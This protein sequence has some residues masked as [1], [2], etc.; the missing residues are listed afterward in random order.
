ML[1]ADDFITI[2]TVEIN[3]SE[4]KTIINSLADEPLFSEIIEDLE[5]YIES[6]TE[7]GKEVAETV[8]EK[9]KEIVQE[10]IQS[11]GAIDS[12][13]MFDQVE[14]LEES[15]LSYSVAETAESPEGHFYPA[16]IE[17]GR[18]EIVPINAK[19]LMFYPKG[20]FGEPIFT[21]KASATKPKP[22]WEPSLIAIESNIDA[23][24]ELIINGVSI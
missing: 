6:Y 18:D 24:V 23:L 16:D 7:S 20:G 17:E 3:D 21:K 2:F 13:L 10:R 9:F 11:I 8:A 5:N 14:V 12:G 15:D 22:F 4:A 1:S 19:A